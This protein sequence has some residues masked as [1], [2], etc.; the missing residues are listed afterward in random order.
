MNKKPIYLITGLAVAAV[1]GLT[2]AGAMRDAQA[3]MPAR[4]HEARG[5]FRI[6]ASYGVKRPAPLRSKPSR[7]H[8]N[9]D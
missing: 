3:N 7:L 8:L 9:L 4:N 6:A 2:E 1:A 5:S